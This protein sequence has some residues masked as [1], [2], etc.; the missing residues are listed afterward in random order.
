MRDASLCDFAAASES[1]PAEAASDD[2]SAGAMVPLPGCAPMSSQLCVARNA[3]ANSK[4]SAAARTPMSSQLRIR[5]ASADD[6]DGIRAVYAPFVD[7]PV[8]FEEEVPSCETYRERIVLVCEKYPCLVAEEGG[9]IIGFSYAHEL[10]E[11]IAFQWNAELSVYLAPTAQGQGVGSR[12][13][14]ALLEL[15]RLMGIKAVYGVVTS[16]NAASERLHRAFGFALM[17]VQPHA[18]FTCGA[19]HDVA[20][21]VR[22]IAPFEDAPAPPAPFPTYASAHPD[23]VSEVIARANESLRL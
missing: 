8:T 6:A 2:A 21:Y 19:W 15:L 17:G 9:H 12:L 14:A 10:R 1:A 18:G 20:W 11:R 5:L 23:Q 4:A 3:P 16:P 13:Y 7:T 22:E